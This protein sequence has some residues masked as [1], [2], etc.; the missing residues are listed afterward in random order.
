MNVIAHQ[1]PL[2]RID[3]GP[4]PQPPQPEPSIATLAILAAKAELE[5]ERTD[6]I[7]RLLEQACQAQGGQAT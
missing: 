2:K 5:R 1:P 7:W 4:K 3:F 6:R